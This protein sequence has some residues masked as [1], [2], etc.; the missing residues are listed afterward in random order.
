M[1]ILVTNDDGIK[2][3]GIIALVEALSKK[4]KIYVCA[5]DGQRSGNSQSITLNANVYVEEVEFPHAERAY[6]TSGTPADCAKIG[7]QFC[8]EAGVKIDMVYAGINM[9]SNLGKDTLYSGTLGAAKEAGVTGYQSVAVSVDSH[10]A[11]HFDYA[12]QLAVEVMDFVYEKFPPSMI[13]NINV[14]NLPSEQIKG[15]KFTQ[16]GDR[17]YDDKFRLCE[18]GDGRAYKLKGCPGDFKNHGEEFDVAA[19]HNDYASITPLHFDYTDY[20]HLKE[21]KKWNLKI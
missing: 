16:L 20:Q 9:G 3:P 11:E 18:G 10:E 5:P 1:N 7:L 12:C 13:I 4:A 2:A 21:I 15:V 8:E 14:P 17:Y 19:A 6:Q